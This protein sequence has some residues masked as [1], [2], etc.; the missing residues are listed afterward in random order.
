LPVIPSFLDM[1]H[2][3]AP[4]NFQRLVGNL[5]P[6]QSWTDPSL[7]SPHL[8]DILI[9]L[10]MMKQ[11]NR[12]LFLHLTQHLNRPNETLGYSGSYIRREIFS[13][14]EEERSRSTP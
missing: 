9:F 4:G 2:Q 13:I 8:R 1:M 5:T 7:S 12:P 11:V 10:D 6:F 14:I 3:R